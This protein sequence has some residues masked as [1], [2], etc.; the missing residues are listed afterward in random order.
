MESNLRPGIASCGKEAVR[1]LRESEAINKDLRAV[2]AALA[3]FRAKRKQRPSF[4][5]R[6]TSSSS[7]SKSSSSAFYTVKHKVDDRDR[8]RRDRHRLY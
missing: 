1:V 2:A 4:F 8:H 6:S 3:A 7:K 5:G